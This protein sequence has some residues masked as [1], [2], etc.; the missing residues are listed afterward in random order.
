MRKTLLATALSVLIGNAAFSQC[1]TPSTAIVESFASSTV[2]TCWTLHGNGTAM[3][4]QGNPANHYISMVNNNQ[5]QLAVLP[6]ADNATGFLSVD[7]AAM[8]QNGILTVDY[9]VMT[10]PSDPSTF[11][12]VGATSLTAQQGVFDTKQLYFNLYPGSGQYIAIRFRSSQVVNYGNILLDN[13]NY[14][15]ECFNATASVTALTQDVTA[16]LDVSGN[17]QVSPQ[18]VNDGSVDGCGDPTLVSLSQVDFTCA[19]LGD[20][21]VT[22]TAYVQ[23]GNSDQETATVTVVPTV[24]AT[25]N[26]VIANLDANGSVTVSNGDLNLSGCTQCSGL[27]YELAET[28]FDCSDIGTFDVTLNAIYGGNIIATGLATIQVV[29]NVAPVPS[30]QDIT[31]TV[32]ATGIVSI[33]PMM[34]DN[35][36]QDNCSS[37]LTMTLSETEFS[38]ADEGDNVVTFT[39]EDEYGNSTTEDVTVTVQ[40]FIEEQSVSADITQFCTVVNTGSL[41]T[42]ASS[43]VGVDYYL[44]DQNDVVVE[45]PI[46]GNGQP[47]TFQT[48]ILTANDEFN[49]YAEK[50]Q[51][52]TNNFALEFDG[53]NDKVA[54]SVNYGTATSTF[55]L[56]AWIY[57]ESA[58]YKRILS[59][60]GLNAGGEVIFDTYDA[61]ANN[62][63]A[64]RFVI[65]GNNGTFIYSVPNVLTLN[66][67]NH[68]AA[69][70]DNGIG[71]LY[72][73]GTLVGT[74]PQ[75]T[76]TTLPGTTYNFQFG[77][78]RIINT[79]EYWN[80]R[81][82][83]IRFW[84]TARTE[85]EIADNYNTCLVGNEPGL[86]EYF[87]LD[88]GAGGDGTVVL[89]EVTYSATLSNFNAQQA[90]A[91]GADI[92]CGS[93]LCG[94]VL[95]Q[96]IPVTVTDLDLS[97]T[98]NG[99]T[100]TANQNGA[101][102][103][104]WNCE[105]ANGAQ[106]G[107]TNQSFT[108]SYSA[109]F[110]VEVTLNG[111]SDF[112][113]CI[114]MVATDVEENDQNN[115]FIYPVP[116][117]NTLFLQSDKSIHAVNVLSAQGALI[118]QYG[119]NQKQI[120]V[121]DLS[122][123]I[124][125]LEVTTELG[126]VKR[127]IIKQ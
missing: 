60:H 15:S 68:V 90:W 65:Y 32:D 77:E 92:N 24:D 124:Y 102:Y 96:T 43:Q 114:V 14:E 78:D 81:M 111:C 42:I 5:D 116:V 13:F 53:Q 23:G 121:S 97:V 18:L 72:V 64:L 54:S 33:T 8:F 11:Y 4:F 40:S 56:E 48:G 52:V 126:L 31:V 79:P 27:T 82:D 38:C 123:G 75:S 100:L 17:V 84:N 59:S 20:N 88:E 112:S 2:P 16:F 35:G 62:G 105:T 49:V 73:D 108:P 87:K 41:I 29:D 51:A 95:T 19:N 45:G 109:S 34:V 1:N 98:Q 106:Q 46:P 66:E 91:F 57:P 69:V 50:P 61:S 21:T 36:T 9:G 117:S 122:P 103:Q 113:D 30:V 83:E 118:K 6:M 110:A 120:D 119:S 22:L 3:A 63:R 80:G 44:R 12:Q 47:I 55:S 127:R 104:W 58:S 37:Y 67:W 71:K 25:S 107:E 89:G 10:D 70:F 101:T 85:Q 76:V 26:A 28:N 125:M 39:V 115:I 86:K 93:A 74:S 99:G 94:K 7:I